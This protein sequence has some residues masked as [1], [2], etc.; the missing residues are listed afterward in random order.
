MASPIDYNRDQLGRNRLTCYQQSHSLH[1]PAVNSFSL[2]INLVVFSTQT[3]IRSMF[4]KSSPN[5]I[6]FMVMVTVRIR[7]NDE[8]FACQYRYR[9]RHSVA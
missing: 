9:L 6:R 3:V 1:K 5:C 4:C 8:R 7:V 2:Y